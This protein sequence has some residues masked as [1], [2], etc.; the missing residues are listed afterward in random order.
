[1][2]IYIYTQIHYGRLWQSN[3]LSIFNPSSLSLSHIHPAETSHIICSNIYNTF[4]F[5]WHL[6]CLPGIS[7]Q[8]RAD[9]C[10]FI[11]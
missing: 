5:L 9:F 11:F 2:C 3:G 4:F 1:M 8:H 7:Q 6:L 10:N